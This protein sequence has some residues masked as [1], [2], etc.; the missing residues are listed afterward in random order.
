MAGRAHRGI[1]RRARSP[2]HDQ[3]KSKPRN[4]RRGS[5][6]AL[7]QTAA[8]SAINRRATGCAMLKNGIISSRE[9]PIAARLLLGYTRAT[10]LHGPERVNGMEISGEAVQIKPADSRSAQARKSHGRSRLTN[11][12]GAVLPDIDGRSVIARRYR[13]ISAAILV[14]QGGADRCSES[15][16]QL[17][18]RFAAAAVLAEQ[19]EG[20]LARGEKIDIAEHATLSST[21]VR[22]AQRIGIDRLPQDI[23]PDP[24]TYAKE[25]ESA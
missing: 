22:L 10:K 7:L 15:R 4:P 16:K 18:R 12:N 21:L 1:R 20:K 19:M 25:R 8:I 2:P 17:I 3:K 14:D 23:T 24:L 6:L 9:G 11:G 5:G 13:D